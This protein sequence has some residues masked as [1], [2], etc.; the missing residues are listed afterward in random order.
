AGQVIAVRLP[1]FIGCTQKRSVE[2]NV[3]QLVASSLNIV[4]EVIAQALANENGMALVTVKEKIQARMSDYAGF[5]CHADKVRHA[6]RDALLL[7]EFVQ[8]HGLTINHA[9]EIAELFM[10]RH[11]ALTS[12]AV[13]TQLT[14]YIDAGGGSRGARMV[15]DPQGKCLPQTRRGA[16]EE[17]RFRSERAED[18][19]HRLTIQYSQGSFITEVKSLRMQPCINGI[20]FEKNWPDFLKGDIYTQ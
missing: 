6:T 20:Y 2:G 4:R 8:Q 14:H 19:N 1:R 11:M 9:G 10:W 18:K 3:A 7:S 16:K 15:I 17:W 12:A 5:I 13:L